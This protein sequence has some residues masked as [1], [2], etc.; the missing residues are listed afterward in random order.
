[1]LVYDIMLCY[2]IGCEADPHH[3]LGADHRLELLRA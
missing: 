3:A 1:M 2:V